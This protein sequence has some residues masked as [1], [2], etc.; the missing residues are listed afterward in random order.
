MADAVAPLWV[1][2]AKIQ[3]DISE[4]VF[5]VQGINQESTKMVPS[6]QFSQRKWKYHPK[7]TVHGILC[8]HRLL[9]HLSFSSPSVFCLWSA[10]KPLEFSI[11]ESTKSNF[12][13]NTW[14]LFSC[15]FYF[16]I[17]IFICS[18]IFSLLPREILLG[19]R[20]ETSQLLFLFPPLP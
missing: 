13:A 20:P 9:F 3:S 2:Y 6:S 1:F 14:F 19:N 4:E 16:A 7:T 8:I 11:W 17:F 10:S 18:V 12:K 5:G 15:I